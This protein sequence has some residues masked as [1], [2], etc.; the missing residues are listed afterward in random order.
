[1]YSL[2]HAS[3][4]SGVRSLSSSSPSPIFLRFLR[5]EGT[6]SGLERPGRYC[7]CR[8]ARMDVHLEKPPVGDGNGCFTT[9][10]SPG[11]F[12]HD[13]VHPLAKSLPLPS[14]PQPH[15]QLYSAMTVTTRLATFPSPARG[16]SP[17][18]FLNKGYPFFGLFTKKS[19][20]C[21]QLMQLFGHSCDDV[22]SLFSSEWLGVAPRLVLSSGD[23]RPFCYLAVVL[24]WWMGCASSFGRHALTTR[25]LSWNP[26]LSF[27]HRVIS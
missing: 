22:G 5:S 16:A 2:R 3:T 14:K 20:W 8:K 18:V 4:R 27:L 12:P 11:P 1:M 26:L 10:R 24:L 6:T 13:L 19:H 17:P 7:G 15:L 25:V 21:R 23:S 9:S